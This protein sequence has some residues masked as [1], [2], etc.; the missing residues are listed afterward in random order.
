[1]G[2]KIFLIA[3]SLLFGLGVATAQNRT[4]SGTVSDNS[5]QPLPGVSVLVEGTS[6]G[7]STDVEGKYSLNVRNG[8]T[9]QFSFFGM[10]TVTMQ[11][12]GR[13]TIDVTM[14]EDAI[15]LDEVVITATGMTRQEKT[16]GYASTTVRSDELTKG[17]AADALSGL[18]GK[19]AGMQ[20]SS[21]GATG[22]S[23]KVIVRGYSSLNSNAPLYVI[24]GV[25]ISNTIG[26][27]QG[28]NNSIDFGSQASDVNPEDIESITV[29]KGASAT[30]LY[31]SRAGN[32]AIIITTKRGSQNEEVKVTYDGSFQASTVLRIPQLQNKFGQGWFYSND[33][34]IFEN[35]SP[36][37][38]GSWGNILDGRQVEWRP[39]AFLAG[40]GERSYTD[41]SY[42][43][44]SLKN[45]Y[46]TGFEMNN[47]V[48]VQGGSRN[49]GFV[50]S[51]GN[52]H[53]NGILPGSNDYYRR[54]NFSFRGNTKIREGLAWLTYSLNYIRKDIRN[55]MTGQ[56]GNGSTIYQDILQYPVNIDYADV[57][58]Y[59]SV[60]NNADN[61][62]TPYAQNPWWTLDHNYS[63]Y[64]DDRIHGSGEFGLQLLKG[65]QFI[66]RGGFDVTNYQQ[67]YYNDLWTFN[68]GSY[69]QV[70][71]ATAENG[72][73]IEQSRRNSQID[74]NFLLNAD[75]RIAEDWSIHGIAGVNVNERSAS[76][77]S[78][79]LS[80]LALN[81]WAS[82]LN[83][84]GAV[85]PA[86]S[87]ITKRRL[88][89]V[90]AQ[91]DLGWKDAVYLTLS[92][93]ND[94]S[95]TLPI[96][97][98]SFFYYGVNGSVILTEL[99]PGMKN[100]VLSFLKIRGG[101]G[102]TGNDADP[103]YTSSYYFLASARGGF[104]RLSFPLNSF[105]GLVKSSRIPSSTLKPE[106]S[107]EAEFGI[108]A[109]FFDNRLNFD[110]AYYDKITENQIIPADLAPESGFTSAVRNI[111]K[112][113]NRGIELAVGIVPV[114]TKDW[115]WN[116]GYTFS[117]NNNKV[118]SLWDDAKEYNIYGLTQGPQ[119]RARV[120]ES[121]TTWVDYKVNTVE[122]ASSPWY[123]CVI[124]NRV[125]GFPTYSTSEY[126]VLGKAEEDFTM[127]FN[128]TLRFKNLSLGFSFDYRK[129]GLMYSATKSIVLFDGNAE[130][131]MYNM[132][133]PW[134]WPNAV[135]QSGT[136]NGKPVYTE[137]NLPISS[138]YNVNGVH[139][140]NYNY[141]KYRD[142]LLDKTYVKLRELNLS[143]RFPVKWF[144][145]ISWL[146]TVE[147]ALVGRNLLMWTPKQGLI[148][149]DNTNYGNDITSQ[150]GE[151]YSAPSTRTFGGNIKIVF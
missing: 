44:N 106:I 17:H 58:D 148:D 74:A 117:K 88:A 48:S 86:S 16:L 13:T 54:H 25:P 51:Y 71:G 136:E 89:G 67:K 53:S 29:L 111:G 31:G 21:A 64:Q 39:G 66:A 23:Q 85:P 24:D 144:K 115:E 122:D 118:K 116:I 87:S 105:A 84:S 42:K 28:L 83:T 59:H 60:Y 72:Q 49:T 41:F 78:G 76:V 147:V 70:N 129:G 68:P 110:V 119:L 69:A 63:T 133:N 26:G 4:V 2:K 55:A 80:G 5:G 104:G 107:T 82:F 121:L 43:E 73:Y 27:Y 90:Y 134:V 8:R 91:A 141:V 61:Y 102:Q 19:V 65:L 40:V 77:L 37:E 15:G 112:I 18:A 22:T 127:G 10:Q 96:D 130:E 46:S 1:M 128:N 113:Q 92:A 149:P 135:Y 114:R 151:Y 9:L 100:K 11:I 140:S 145:D 150:Y 120:G 125:T 12:G 139:Y 50:A 47:T 38:N 108:D 126:E 132:R 93:R 146:S 98:N 101:Y 62:F 7:T 6:I 137:N 75:Y 99:F 142:A 32:G 94:W 131:T 79:T 97:D 57:K 3:L 103:Y 123:G 35:Y 52:I 30:A 95:S 56:G 20:I 138:W 14:L 124:V 143:Y 36:T 45:F 81:Q 33:G 34:H 109:R